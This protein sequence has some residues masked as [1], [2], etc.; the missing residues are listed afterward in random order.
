MCRDQSLTPTFDGF[1]FPFRGVA[2]LLIS[3]M[4]FTL[5]RDQRGAAKVS[6]AFLLNLRV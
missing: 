2:W 4:D 3:S 6:T 5:P 1:A